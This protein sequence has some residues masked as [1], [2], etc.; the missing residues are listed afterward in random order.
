MGNCLVVYSYNEISAAELGFEFS[1]SFDVLI[2]YFFFHFCLFDGVLHF[3][4]SK[5]LV[6]FFFFKY[7]VAF[8]SWLFYSPIFFIS[9]EY[10]SMINSMPISW[11]YIVVCI[12]VSR[13]F[14]F[15]IN[16][17]F[18]ILCLIA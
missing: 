10:F 5:I 1:C 18:W 15:L 13:S 2:T 17:W 12:R 8:L 11:L 16:I 3:R 14:S 9:T 4:Y 6:I 7:F